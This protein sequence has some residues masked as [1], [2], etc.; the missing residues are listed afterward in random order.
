[1]IFLNVNI[2]VNI[3]CFQI[4]VVAMTMIS[5]E[6]YKIK[7]DIVF[8]NADDTFYRKSRPRNFFLNQPFV[9]KTIG[10]QTSSIIPI[11]DRIVSQRALRDV[12]LKDRVVYSSGFPTFRHRP[13]SKQNS[14]VTTFRDKP[15]FKDVMLKNREIR[16]EQAVLRDN[17][18]EGQSL[19]PEEIFEGQ[20]STYKSQ[21]PFKELFT[22][23]T[24]F[25]NLF[26]G[27]LSSAEQ[28]SFQKQAT[29]V[30]SPSISSSIEFYRDNYIKPIDSYEQYKDIPTSFDEKPTKYSMLIGV[31]QF[32]GHVIEIF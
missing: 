21:A 26:H 5:V 6:T 17:P 16:G 20:A 10:L 14:F 32:R 22:T 2:F 27:Q 3:S 8:S 29:F 23:G 1:M 24:S 4:I 19:T 9:D 28:P 13:M 12:L 31:I 15:L 25:K 7:R 18:L 30:E 11:R